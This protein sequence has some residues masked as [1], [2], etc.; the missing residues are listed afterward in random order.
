MKS[1]LALFVPL[2]MFNVALSD[3]KG[4]VPVSEVKQMEF[5]FN[6]PDGI[7]YT[8]TAEYTVRTSAGD[9]ETQ[10]DHGILSSK[11]TVTK[12]DK[13][14]I[15]K[16]EPQT[17][18]IS[19][20][21]RELNNPL[22]KFIQSSVVT[23]EAD[24]NGKILSLKG[25]EDLAERLKKEFKG[26]D[27]SDLIGKI[28]L[29]ALTDQAAGEWN[30]RLRGLVGKK[31][32]VGQ[33]WVEMESYVLPTGDKIV[34]FKLITIKGQE[35]CGDKDCL[36]LRF[37]FTSDR[38]SLGQDS[39]IDATMLPSS[40]QPEVQVI[41]QSPNKI[42]G[43]GEMVIEPMTM[44]IYAENQLKTII[45]VTTTTDGVKHQTTL[46]ERKKYQTHF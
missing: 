14:F 13:G 7:K 41:A 18:T 20:N 22:A 23:I 12:F 31:V 8:T 28:D 19:H 10:V 43:W 15:F 38:N 17:I 1:L 2:L 5:R 40:D 45:L 24:P 44:L 6:P 37:D 36:R 21:A 16:T 25:Y 9:G 4:A 27:I 33:R 26:Q 39:A 3:Q 11:T 30:R 35:K 46:T 29:N 34:Y 42:K 32:D